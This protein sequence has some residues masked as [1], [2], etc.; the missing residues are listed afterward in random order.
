MKVGTAEAYSISKVVDN[1]VIFSKSGSIAIL[2]YLEQPE[3]YSLNEQKFDNRI[4]EFFSAYRTIPEDCFVHKQDIYLLKP[5]D[6]ETIQG[7]LFLDE[8]MRKHFDGREGIKHQCILAFIITKLKSLEKSYLINPFQYREK[9]EEEDKNKLIQFEEN[10]RKAVNIIKNVFHTRIKPLNYED[11]R[12]FIYQYVNCFENAGYY[13]IDFRDKSIGENKFDLF[14]FPKI[15]Y[16]PDHITNIKKDIISKDEFI[17][18]EGSMDMLGET[19]ECNHVFNQIIYFQGNNKRIE[20]EIDLKMSEYGK[21]RTMSERINSKYLQFETFLK[22]VSSPG[23]DKILV[24]A[25]YNLIIFDKDKEKLKRAKT[26]VESLLQS[27]NINFYKPE[28]EILK[29]VFLGS[30]IGRESH[31]HKDN[32]FISHIKQALCLCTNTTMPRSDEKGIW[33]NS[34]VN[35]QPLKRDIWDEDKKRIDAR[36]GI[37]VANTGGGKS[38][39]ALNIIMQFLSQGVNAVVAEFGRSFQFITYLYPD[40]SAHIA[41]NANRPLGINP[42]RVEPGTMLTQ[43]KLSLLNSIILKTWRI[44]ENFEN[45]HVVVSITKLLR[46]YYEI[47]GSGHSYEDFYYFIVNGGESLLHKLDIFQKEYFDIESFKHICSEFITGGRY[48][49]VFKADETTAQIIKEKQFV[50]FELT[51]IKK[52]PFLVSLILLILQETIDSNILSDRGKRGVLIFDEFAETQ[53]IKDMYSGEEVIQTVAILYQKIRKENGAVYTIIQ[54]PSQLPPNNYTA[55]IIANTQVLI[56]LPSNKV[57]YTRIKETFELE[58]HQMYQL[59]SLKNDTNTAYRPYS[60]LWMKLGEESFVI[61]LELSREAFLAFQ[62]D[63]KV[64]KSLNEEF[65]RTNDM[66]KAIQIIKNKQL[67]ENRV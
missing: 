43:E 5:F 49:M 26:Q 38:V 20:S 61:R 12:Y 46:K 62:T 28:K 6:G 57:T 40:I 63:G 59:L 27:S 22:D 21:L 16:F 53:A 25:H 19:L 8:A 44:R 64:W 54:D 2:Y 7:N 32:F 35:Q 24:K 52:D 13:D 60:E 9:L 47:R 36:N 3:K 18:W 33:F 17:F 15:E 55:G 58:E 30:I 29:D 50:V 34:R 23:S 4:E 42:F 39:T 31:L 51:E 37:I 11:T 66:K 56:V 65:E 45:T 14:S 67:H 1:N 10:V 48:E 41:Y